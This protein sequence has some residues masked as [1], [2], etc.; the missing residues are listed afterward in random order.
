MTTATGFFP[1]N[2]EE[3][4]KQAGIQ[5]FVF[6]KEGITQV[7]ILPPYSA[8]GIWC[9]EV[10]EHQVTI[11]GRFLTFPCPRF[12]EDAACPFC[13][14]GGR[15][16]SMGDEDSVEAAKA[17]RGKRAFLFNALIY[18]AP[19]SNLD[20]RSGVKVLKV[21]KT[22]RDQ[23]LDLDQDTAGGWGNIYNLEA[24]HD[25]RITGLGAGR[26][27]KYIVKGVPGRT[28]ILAQLK[29][30]GVATILKPIDLEGLLPAQPYAKLA[31]ALRDSRGYSAPAP[32]AQPPTTPY[33][34]APAASF[35]A[36]SSAMAPPDSEV[37]N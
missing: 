31:Q 34:A 9:R 10:R 24:G 7:R 35:N 29:A 23:I 21:G 25:L 27:R 3:M 33:P 26:E 12:L 20:L 6:L 18:S 28:D 17:F 5:P 32:A 30:Q 36:G 8:R 4:D 19:G 11:E 16:H 2:Q 15:L 37:P 1:V 14:E 22:V 13:E